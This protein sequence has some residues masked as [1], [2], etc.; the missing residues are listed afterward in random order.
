MGQRLGRQVLVQRLERRRAVGEHKDMVE[1]EAPVVRCRSL[2]DLSRVQEEHGD[3]AEQEA[4]AEKRHDQQ[5]SEAARH[6]L[7]KSLWLCWWID[8]VGDQCCTPKKAH[9]RESNGDWTTVEQG[10]NMLGD[11]DLHRSE[12]FWCHEQ[13]QE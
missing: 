8:D 5:S 6:L 10:T 7:V 12:L 13:A 9:P 3:E 1:V 4:G 11:Q 2:Q